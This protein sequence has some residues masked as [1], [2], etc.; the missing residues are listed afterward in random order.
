MSIVDN[1]Y[2]LSKIV[3]FLTYSL[4]YSVY[5]IMYYICINSDVPIS[6]R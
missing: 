5:N 1:L 4:Y 6:T 3:E 2:F